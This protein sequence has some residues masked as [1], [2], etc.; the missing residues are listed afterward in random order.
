MEKKSPR[1]RVDALLH[2][3]QMG[4]GVVRRREGGG[5]LI[6]SIRAPEMPICQYMPR[7]DVY[8]QYMPPPQNALK[9]TVSQVRFEKKKGKK[10]ERP[11]G[12]NL[13]C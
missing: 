3:F 8:C 1:A 5:M 9:T 2:I 10:R 11:F 4:G 6:C 7:T 12:E 13:G